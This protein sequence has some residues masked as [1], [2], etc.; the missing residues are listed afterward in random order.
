[1]ENNKLQEK[2]FAQARAETE[3]TIETFRRVRQDWLNKGFA[4]HVKFLDLVVE[5]Y[6]DDHKGTDRMQYL[7]EMFHRV[8]NFGNTNLFMD[9]L[10][11]FISNDLLDDGACRIEW[12]VLDLSNS[13]QLIWDKEANEHKHLVVTQDNPQSLPIV[14]YERDDGRV[15]DVGELLE[16]MGVCF[17]RQKKKLQEYLEREDQKNELLKRIR[18]GT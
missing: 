10:L 3:N 13:P 7:W 14:V 2:M 11:G 17:E 12:R 16:A 6:F 5:W 15:A 8:I 4:D 18:E 9:S 1:M